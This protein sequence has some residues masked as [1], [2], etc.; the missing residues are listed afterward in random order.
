MPSRA[1]QLWRIAHIQLATVECQNVLGPLVTSNLHR[2][3]ATFRL[4]LAIWLR[5][6]HVSHFIGPSPSMAIRRRYGLFRH[7]SIS[8]LQSCLSAPSRC[9]HVS[10][11]V[12]LVVCMTPR[13]A[14][15]LYGASPRPP[16]A[17]RLVASVHR[18]ADL[19]ACQIFPKNVGPPASLSL[20]F[21]QS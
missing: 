15:P 6:L 9:S 19:P 13:L 3:A 1:R 2:R 10:R 5:L 18:F 21:I 14:C 20:F 16:G 11:F 8:R 12:A 17:W 4:V 7:I